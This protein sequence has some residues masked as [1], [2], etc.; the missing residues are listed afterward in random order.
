MPA[1]SR[2]RSTGT[3]RTATQS[4]EAPQSIEAEIVEVGP[5]DLQEFNESIN[6]GLYGPSGHGKTRLAGGAPNAI[7]LS[8]EKGVVSAQRG[9]STAQVIRAPDW[10]HALAGVRWADNNM[11]P[12]D[13]LIIDSHTKM[14]ILY[15][16]WLLRKKNEEN[17]SRDL[18]IPALQDHQKWQNAFMRWSDHII[19]A[20]YN[21]IFICTD[22]IRENDEGDTEV[23]P[24]IRGG[25]HLEV[26]RYI[27]SQWDVGLYYARSD[28]ASKDGPLVRRALA[29]PFPPYWAKDR[30]DAIGEYFD[31]ENGYNDGMADIID[32]IRGS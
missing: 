30:Y 21:T 32:L 5:E 10:E 15:I 17:G 23:L 13:W 28:R 16:R 19:E 6:I 27:I 31:I 2:R 12:D 1:S 3:R 4:R 9:G 7:F 29:Q 8:T 25:K 14:Q 20:Q 24:Q 18:D 22:M 26:C 11:G